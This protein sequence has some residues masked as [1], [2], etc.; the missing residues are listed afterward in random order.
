[1]ADP[2]GFE[3]AISSVTGWHVGP[4]HH[5]S[6]RRRRRIAALADSGGR[7]PR[8]PDM[9]DHRP[10]LRHRHQAHARDA[11]SHGRGRGRRRRLRRRPDGH[12]ARGAR[13]GA[14]RQGSRPVRDLA[15]RRATSSPSWPTSQRGKE[16]IAGAE[17]HIMVRRGG[18]PRRG[19]RDDPCGRSTSSPTARCDLDEIARCVPRPDRRPRARSRASWPSR[20]PTPMS[21]GQ[22]LACRVHRR[23]SRPIA[24]ERGVPLHIDGA[25]FF[26][27]VVALEESTRASSPARPIRV[28]F[29]LSKGLACP[30]GSRA[31]WLDATSSGGRAGAPQAGRWRDAPGRRPR[32]GRARRAARRRR[33]A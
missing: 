2:T 29:C 11:P 1:M 30:V 24:H 23:R 14:A 16:T 19:R 21:M 3:P 12:R 7:Y 10:P 22:P 32:R 13:R 15:A 17:S 33:R 25:R 4:L 18:E 28:T 5:G 31:R 26:N 27:A 8:A 9:P 20:T 6:E